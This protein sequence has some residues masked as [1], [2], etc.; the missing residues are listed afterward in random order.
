VE[1][2]ALLAAADPRCDFPGSIGSASS[3]AR[4]LEDHSH[5]L[6]EH[7]HI[8]IRQIDIHAVDSNLTRRNSSV[9]DQIVHPIKATQ[10]SRLSATRRSDEGR[11]LFLGDLEVDALQCFGSA[12]TKVY[13]IDVNDRACS[14]DRRTL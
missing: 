12:I 7:S 4:A 3:S 14:F 2:E 11:Y 8:N 1:Y 9:I 10:Q 13:S 5:S 6:P